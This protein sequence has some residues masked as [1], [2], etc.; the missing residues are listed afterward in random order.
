MLPAHGL[1]VYSQPHLTT[2][3][4][5]CIWALRSLLR[6]GSILGESHLGTLGL[7]PPCAGLSQS[8]LLL[9]NNVLALPLMLG[10]LLSSR[11]LSSVWH[12]PRLRDPSFQ[13][14]LFATSLGVIDQGI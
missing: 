7:T 11:E 1:R 14:T 5:G 4:W 13:V 10:M 2:S 12:Y 3:H 9:Y 8:A 6:D